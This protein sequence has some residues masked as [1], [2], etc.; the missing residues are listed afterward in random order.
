LIEGG[1]EALGELSL[2]IDGLPLPRHNVCLY[3]QNA[4]ENVEAK[5]FGELA[6]VLDNMRESSLLCTRHEKER[7]GEEGGG[8]R[9][10]HLME[11]HASIPVM[12]TT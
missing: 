3:P 10:R 12:H 8:G 7:K 2:V 1:F 6:L 4:C 5:G 9:R 11:S